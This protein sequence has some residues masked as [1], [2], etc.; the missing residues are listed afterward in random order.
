[1]LDQHRAIRGRDCAIGNPAVGVGLNVILVVVLVLVVGCDFGG[2]GPGRRVRLP[3]IGERPLDNLC[4]DTMLHTRLDAL[5]GVGWITRLERIDLD[6]TQVEF[7][8]EAIHVAEPPER[9]KLW[10]VDAFDTPYQ[11]REHDP[12]TSQLDRK[13]PVRSTRSPD[14]R[15]RWPRLRP[16]SE[17][18]H[19]TDEAGTSPAKDSRAFRVCPSV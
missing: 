2:S 8:E 13:C 1:M 9:L 3:R 17:A 5:F 14:P 10:A 7:G 11:Q 16:A 15:H 4:L 12:R 19:P 18:V 6:I